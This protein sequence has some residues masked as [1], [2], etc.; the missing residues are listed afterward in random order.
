M[1]YAAAVRALSPLSVLLL[2]AGLSIGCGEGPPPSNVS[3]TPRPVSSRPAPAATEHARG[4]GHSTGVTYEEA[5]AI[6]EDITSLAGERELTNTELAAP[7]RDAAF[8][9][10]CETPEATKVTV[11]V[12]I[13]NGKVLGL[14]VYTRPDD[15]TIAECIDREV[16]ALAWPENK[17]R[18]SFTT[19]Y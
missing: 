11:R 17:H 12:V 15:P 19:T 16:R 8:L 13:K 1:K 2:V 4:A 6:P 9:A 5:L 7:M 18:D 10:R 3:G 14:S